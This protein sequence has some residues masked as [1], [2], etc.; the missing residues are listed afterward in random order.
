MGRKPLPVGSWGLIRTIN[1]KTAKG[2]KRVLARA[3]FRD[4]DGVTRVVEASGKSATAASQ[5]LRRKLENRVREGMTGD[6]TGSTRFKDAAEIWIEYIQELVDD[7]A[8][9][10]GTVQTYRGQLDKHLMPTMGELR[11][12]ELTTPVIDRVIRQIKTRTSTATAKSCR[13]VV[14]GVMGMAV[15][16]GAIGHNPV[17]DMT[18]L[19]R[20]RAPEPRALAAE[21]RLNLM[22]LLYGTDLA[23]R[24]DLGDLAFFMLA[25]GVRIG[26][27]LALEWQHVDLEAGSVDI[28]GTLIRVKGE[29]LLRKPTKSRAGER[30]LPL[31]TSAVSMLRN[32][33]RPGTRLDTPVFPDT[34][35]GFRDPTNVRRSL[36]STLRNTE[37]QWV[38]T[39][40]FRK[41]AA[42][43]LDEANLT[44]RSVADHLGHSRP[45]M[46]Q[47][48]YFGRK[49]AESR[50]AMALDEVV[51]QIDRESIKR[52]K[53]V[54]DDA[55]QTP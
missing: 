18:R 37:L 46:T 40:T 32:R 27:A 8:R 43:V 47:D 17:R 7:G 23:I 16:Q 10:P 19:E 1:R 53:S 9:S 42:T 21:E 51:S 6:L 28:D 20:G 50:V 54:A 5:E 55:G 39:H 41:T 33:F 31:P 12:G 30:L 11:L 4:F 49:I 26:E 2:E 44:A 45:S 35:G 15:R 29:G 14:S 22:Q 36:R 52:G 48:V 24:H 34:E 25:T 3:G 38:T 13:S